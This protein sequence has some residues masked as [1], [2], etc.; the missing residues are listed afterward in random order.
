MIRLVG[1]P[2]GAGNRHVLVAVSHDEA[3]ASPRSAILDSLVA[4][5]GA[6]QS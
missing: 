3:A 5:P 6:V 4:N 1:W 2:D